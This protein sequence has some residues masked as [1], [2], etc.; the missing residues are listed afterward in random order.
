M[1]T[2][3]EFFVI[4]RLTSGEQLMCA[5]QS[6]DDSYVELLHPMIV[7]TVPN[8]QTGREMVTVTPFCAFAEDETYTL[9]KKNVL[10]IKRLS[11]KIIP[12]Y[13]N[14]VQESSAKFT[15]RGEPEVEDFDHLK[16]IADAMSAIEQLRPIADETEEEKNRV[17]VEGNETVH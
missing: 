8:F 4:V 2:G 17:F 5:L 3:N 16:G 9:D 13:L 1:L 10:F 15:P 6:E 14:T 7:R 11:Q 12:H